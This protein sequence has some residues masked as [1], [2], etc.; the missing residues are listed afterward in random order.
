MTTIE[1]MDWTRVIAA[2]VL[3]AWGLF[4]VISGI[5]NDGKSSFLILGLDHLFDNSEYR[6]T[7]IRIKNVG[8]G[9]LSIGLSVGLLYVLLKN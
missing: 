2:I 1:K 5:K 4:A 7:L 6:T 3:F 8:L 9:L